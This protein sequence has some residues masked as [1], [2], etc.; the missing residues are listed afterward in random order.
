MGKP[1]APHPEAIHCVLRY[2]KSCLGLF[3]H[4]AS[5]FWLKAFCDSNWA[6]C[7]DSHKS[8]TDFWMFLSS[9]LISWKCKWQFTVSHSTAESEYRAM[10][11]IYCELQWLSYLLVDLRVPYVMSTLLFCNN[12]AA[13]HIAPNPIFHEQ[14]HI[15]LDCHFVCEK[16]QAR[17]IYHLYVSSSNQFCDIFTKQLGISQ[18]H[19]LL[20][21]LGVLDP[22]TPAWGGCGELYGIR[23]M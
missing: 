8:L 4:V 3:Y 6:A 20:S 13:L 9:S 15:D 5:D 18:F 17:L 7:P 2:L 23:T 22:H 19:F 12:K 16:L 1:R 21:K 11:S 14:L 10:T